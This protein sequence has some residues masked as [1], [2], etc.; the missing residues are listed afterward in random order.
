MARTPVPARSSAQSSQRPAPARSLRSR[1]PLWG[2]V[3]AV[4][5]L[6]GV[7]LIVWAAGRSSGRSI[8][9]LAVLHTADYHS[10]A[11]S[12]SDPSVVFFG[13]HNGVLH[14]DD[15][16]RSFHALVSRTNFDAMSLA[17]DPTSPQR[18]Y[19]AGHDIFQTSA[20]GG[21]TWQALS[22]TLPG[23]DI[24]GFT[25]SPDAP[26]HLTAFVV[27][28]GLLASGDAGAQ[29][30]QLAARVPDDIMSLASA[31][32]SPETLYAVSMQAGLLR[33]TD[34]GATFARAS[35]ALPQ[36]VDAVAVDPTS[37]LTVYAGTEAGLF[38]SADGGGTWSKLPFPGTNAM[39]V[40]ASRAQ[41]GLLFA[42]TLKGDQG[43]VER[44]TDGGQT[45]SASR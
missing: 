42:I 27:G 41:P 2:A 43:L 37:P 17:I 24:H 8:T 11:L 39:V 13:H 22:T 18:V 15:G 40:G 20:D 38:K 31:G 10:L 36:M 28:H 4:L 29:W 7:G 25:M 35:S 21:A 33:S 34:G 6:A 9:G 19:L 5:V 30:Q 44:S 16:G 14:S 3:V 23:R 1:W 32:G 12:P 45:W 26:S